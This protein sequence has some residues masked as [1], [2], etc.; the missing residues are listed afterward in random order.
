MNTQ[1]DPVSFYTTWSIR[2]DWGATGVKNACNA[3]YNSV[4]G[5][6]VDVEKVMYDVEGVETTTFEEA[7]LIQFTVTVNK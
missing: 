6:S 1:T 4:W 7:D 2:A 5:T 3:F